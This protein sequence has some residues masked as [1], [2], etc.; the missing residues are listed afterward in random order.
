M[1]EENIR[2]NRSINEAYHKLNN[3]I[4]V[5]YVN[6]AISAKRLLLHTAACKEVRR[7]PNLAQIRRLQ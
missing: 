2:T 6:D 3:L 1:I 7:V 4:H 5:T